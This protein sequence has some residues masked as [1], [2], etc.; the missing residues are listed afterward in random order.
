MES[1]AGKYFGEDFEFCKRQLAHHHPNLGID[2]DNMGIDH[3]LLKE[4]DG[5]KEENKGKGKE[6]GDINSFSP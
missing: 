1:L 6:K 3:D 4:E 5:K 2:L